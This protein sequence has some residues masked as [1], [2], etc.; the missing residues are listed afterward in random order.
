M[1]RFPLWSGVPVINL[2]S[3]TCM[4]VSGLS[5][6]RGFRDSPF[7]WDVLYKISRCSQNRCDSLLASGHSL[8]V[9]CFPSPA[10]LGGNALTQ[11]WLVWVLSFFELSAVF[12]CLYE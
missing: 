12:V 1:L 5:L 7:P 3:L 4:N 8:Y 6:C 11:L 10:V 9:C 2:V